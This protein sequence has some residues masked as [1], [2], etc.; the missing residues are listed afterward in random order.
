MDSPG[1]TGGLGSE[2]VL[3]EN[4]QLASVIAAALIFAT[5]HKHTIVRIP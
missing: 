2:I 5:N 1:R 4:S 3:V